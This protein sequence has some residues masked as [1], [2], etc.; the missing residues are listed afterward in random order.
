LPLTPGST[1]ERYEIQGLIGRGGMGEVY[2]AIDTRLHRPVALKVLRTDEQAS[3]VVAEAGGV[4]RLLREAR[5]AA[6]LNHANSVAIYELGEAEG[7]AYIAMELVTGATL[8]KYVGATNVSLETKVSWLVDAAR[9]LWAAHRAGLVHRDVKPGNIMV[10]EEGVVKVLDFGLAKPVATK[11][12]LAGF[13]T[14]MG[15]VLG[16]P[17]YM[18]PEQLEGA[19]VDASAD[20]FAFGLTAYELI[21]GVY[22]GGPL[23]GA[24]QTLDTLDVGASNELARAVARMMAR[25]PKDRFPTME[26]AAHALRASAPGLR[27][28]APPPRDVDA[29][30]G[31]RPHASDAPTTARAAEPVSASREIGVDVDMSLAK[32][33]TLPLATAWKMAS[34]EGASASPAPPQSFGKTLP[35]GHQAVPLPPNTPRAA[36]SSGRLPDVPAPSGAF[37]P[38]G[39]Y[40]SKAADEGATPSSRTGL[41]RRER[42]SSWL[43]MVLLA[44]V[45]VAAGAIAAWLSR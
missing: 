33:S 30:G 1:F 42:P 17:R 14:L 26:D 2:R 39:V 22:C 5:T 15:Q 7:I 23:A 10:S 4:A 44:L 36:P 11:K 38:S 37:S 25:K 12:E 32:G 34:G 45:A 21:S 8:R 18:A 3:G 40:A 19:P 9:A 35:L 41:T 43:P 31:E 28:A 20:Q 24:P 6:A 27:A 13:E 16:T 29:S